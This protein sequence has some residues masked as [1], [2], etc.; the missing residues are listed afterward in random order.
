MAKDNGKY[1]SAELAS[2]LRESPGEHVREWAGLVDNPDTLRLLERLDTSLDK[3]LLETEIGQE[4][5]GRE[6]TGTIDRAVRDGSVSQMK[7]ATGFNQRESEGN[8]DFFMTVANRL[9]N[10]GSVGLVFGNPG[11][12]KTS[13]CVDVAVCWRALTGGRVISNI[14][15][16]G[17]DG[18]F[19][20][21][22]E[23]LELMANFPCQVLAV[24]DEVAQELS[25]FGSGSKQAQAF[26][27]ALLFIRKQQDRHG[28]HPKKGSVLSVAHTRTKTAK[29]LRRLASFA[30]EKPDKSRK[31][32]A[33]VLNSEG[34]KDEW[35]EGETY[36]GLTATRETFDEYQASE[37]DVRESYD[38]DDSDDSGPDYDPQRRADIQTVISL[39]E[40]GAT[41]TE[42]GDM[43]GFSSSWVSDRVS[44]QENGEFDGWL[45]VD[46]SK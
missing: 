14:P 22:T 19:S 44:E 10:E 4:I 2:E 37:F 8:D 40:Q 34:G 7:A 24:I 45:D 41:Y 33:R 27:D 35:T 38:S 20:S 32:V 21:D 6:A 39:V 25:G 29:S 1:A 5:I 3:S 15:W 31:H 42:A 13:L 23:M 11:S 26:S 18:H 12:G 17:A 46:T 36:S 30:I 28:D 9:S 16:D 43:V